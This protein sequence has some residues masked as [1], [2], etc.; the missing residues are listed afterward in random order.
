MST[1]WQQKR[2]TYVSS[3]KPSALLQPWTLPLSCSHRWIVFVLKAIPSAGALGPLHSHLLSDF[4]TEITPLPSIINLFWVPAIIIARSP[5]LKSLGP[6]H[7]F[8]HHI[9]LSPLCDEGLS[10]SCLSYLLKWHDGNH[11]MPNLCPPVLFWWRTLTGEG[12]GTGSLS[13]R[14]PWDKRLGNCWQWDR[15][16]WNTENYP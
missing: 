6:S 16:V 1:W 8:S 10:V 12:V 14:S 9:I 2:N 15:C 13:L 5:S 4:P 11:H 7:P 3:T